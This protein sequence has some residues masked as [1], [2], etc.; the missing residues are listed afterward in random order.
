M[1]PT[2]RDVARAAKVSV[3]TVSNVLNHSPLVR[4]ET[5]QRV[6]EAIAALDFHPDAAARSIITKRTNTIGLVRTEI[7]PRSDKIETDPFV[8][9]LIEG[10]TSAAAETGIGLT[11]WTIPAGPRETA[12]YKRLVGG[13]VVDGLILFGLREDDPRVPLLLDRRFPFVLFGRWEQEPPIHW[14]DVDGAHGI[15]RAVHHLVELGHRRIAYLAPPAEQ[16]LAAYRWQGFAEGMGRAGLPID[17]ALVLEGDYSEASG[18]AAALQLLSLPEPPSALVCSNDRM[19][20]GAMRAAGWRGRAVGRDWSVVGFDD[21]PG[22]R[23]SAPPLTTIRQPLHEI[24]AQL[25]A[26]LMAVINHQPTDALSGQLIKPELR[27]RESTASPP[28]VYVW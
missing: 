21:I 18:E 8:L 2:I 12:L 9:D 26:L 19:A 11:F 7:R 14:I 4:D 10:V 5:R 22:A 25:F 27:I 13:R 15:E 3:G 28:D 6:L 23:F 1:S 24:G 17:P 16:P 20:I